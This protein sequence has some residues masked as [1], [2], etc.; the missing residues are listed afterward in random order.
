MAAL[1][2]TPVLLTLV[3]TIAL[4]LLAIELGYRL[5]RRWMRSHRITNVS[6]V[7]VGGTLALL[8]FFLAILVGMAVDRYDGRR[9]MVVEE[10][11][12]IGTTWLRAEYL[13]EPQSTE[14]RRILVDYVGQRLLITNNAQRPASLVRAQELRDELWAQTVEVA[15][16]LPESEPIGLFIATVNDTIDVGAKREVALKTWQL[17]WTLWASAYAVA[18]VSML[19]VGAHNAVRGDRNLME[20]TLLAIVFSVVMFFIVDL[21][22]PYEGLLQV[23][24]EA[25]SALQ[26]QISP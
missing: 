8:A 10:A 9:A 14:V 22:R 21:D 4:S 13:P 11:N 16:A 12:A 15:R 26:T 5:G 20:T 17:P 24:Q 18:F 23:S 19:L 2:G 3:L 1:E 25:M 6:D 7:L